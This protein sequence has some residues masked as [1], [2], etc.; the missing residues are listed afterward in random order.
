MQPAERV[1]HATPVGLPLRRS[2][3]Y[4][5]HH[6]QTVREQPAVSCWDW[7]RHGQTFTVEVLEERGL[8]REIS[9]APRTETTNREL[10]MDAHAPHVVGD[11]AGE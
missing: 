1:G 10:P 3:L 9:I 7:H 4:V 6:H 11:S 8:P 5:C 2:A